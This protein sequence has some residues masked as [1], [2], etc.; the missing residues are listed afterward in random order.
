[1][2]DTMEPHFYVP[3]RA[4]Y[5]A[6]GPYI[7]RVQG[8]LMPILWDF[9]KG[10]WRVAGKNRSPGRSRRAWLPQGLTGDLGRA[11]SRPPSERCRGRAGGVQGSVGPLACGWEQNLPF[12]SADQ[13]LRVLTF[14]AHDM[15]LV[16]SLV[17]LT[18]G[19]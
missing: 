4:L 3:S 6:P 7:T 2:S 15:L 16:T 13:G 12:L 5:S 18:L 8:T 14:R 9:Y 11:T 10:G 17:Y 1:M 19:P